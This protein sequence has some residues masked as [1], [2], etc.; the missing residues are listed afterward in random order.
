MKNL[1][2]IRTLRKQL[3][4]AYYCYENSEQ[5]EYTPYQQELADSKGIILPSKP[6]PIY[7]NEE[8]KA[9]VRHLYK[10]IAFYEK[11]VFKNN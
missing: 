1:D 11:K 3:D 2:V 5:C 7:D 9:N 8:E 6:E 4:Y 10:M